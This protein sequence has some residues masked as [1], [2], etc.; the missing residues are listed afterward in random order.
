MPELTDYT[1]Y[2]LRT[3]FMRGAGLVAETFPKGSHPRDASVLSMLE[4]TGPVSQ[5]QLVE[6]L[7]VNRSVMVKLI[8]GLEA[9]G[10]VERR[11]N[12]ED[13]RSYALYP[14]SAG[15]RELEAMA[16]FMDRG[17]SV[18]AAALSAAERERLIELLHALVQPPETAMSRRLGFLIT[19][20]HHASA[21]GPTRS[22]AAADR[23]PA[24]RRADR[25]G[26]RGPV[27]ARAR[28]PAARVGPGGGRDGRRVGGARDGRAAPRSGRPALECAGGDR[29]GPRRACEAARGKLDEATRELVAADR[30]GR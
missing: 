18:F 10:L 17:E 4:A 30:Y 8:D 6:A 19:Q 12:P 14:T 11:R 28:G 20:A 26:G 21:P 27:P 23:G 13:R 3:A 5:Q 24:F 9:R 29:R 22:C 1:G 2:L 16:P 7:H 25:L 15:R